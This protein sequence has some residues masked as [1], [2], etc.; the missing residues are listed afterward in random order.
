VI[1]VVTGCREGDVSCGGR[2]GNA[3]RIRHDNGMTTVY[4]HLQGVNIKPGQQ[5]KPGELI[6]TVGSTGSSTGP[7]LHFGVQD[8]RG[9]YVDPARYIRR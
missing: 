2:L 4:G 9:N 8:A 7:H 6:G 1:Q 5:V 3:V